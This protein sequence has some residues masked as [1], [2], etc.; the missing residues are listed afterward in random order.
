MGTT[1]QSCQSRCPAPT[2]CSCQVRRSMEEGQTSI[3][4]TVASKA[5]HYPASAQPS[6]RSH[7]R[8]PQGYPRCTTSLDRG[9]NMGQH[10]QQH[11][12]PRTLELMTHTIQHQLEAAQ[13]QSRDET[14]LQYTKW[15]QQGEAKGLKG[16]FRPLKASEL[17][18]QRPC[19]DIPVA[20][21]MRHR[22]H[23][24]QELWRPTEDNQ[25]MNRPSIQSEAK[26]QIKK[27]YC[28]P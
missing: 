13:A 27:L 23:T 3:L 22:L 18:W 24:W 15:I 6:E 17:S 10:W 25:V 4:G 8:F 2:T 1:R 12:D 21:R 26:A 28:H 9:S 19:R 7:Q 16:L 20:D 14:H 5:Q 11:K